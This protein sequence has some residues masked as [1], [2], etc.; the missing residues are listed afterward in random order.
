MLRAMY[1]FDQNALERTPRFSFPSFHF[2][3]SP[4]WKTRSGKNLRKVFF[5]VSAISKSSEFSTSHIPPTEINNVNITCIIC[6]C[7]VLIMC[8]KVSVYF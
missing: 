8:L 7:Y 5:E 1:V 2:G 6:I 4:K 3:Y